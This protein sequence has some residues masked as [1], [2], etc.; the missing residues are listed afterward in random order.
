MRG[1]GTP[2]EVG[3]VTDARELAMTRG[4]TLGRATV[5]AANGVVRY[6][7]TVQSDC[8]AYGVPAEPTPLSNEQPAELEQSVRLRSPVGQRVGTVGADRRPV[9]EVADCVRAEWPPHPE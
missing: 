1:H 6:D 5:V 9:P 2:A 3:E 4:A 7:Q 8:T